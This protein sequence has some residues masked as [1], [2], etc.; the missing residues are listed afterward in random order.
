MCRSSES[1]MSSSITATLPAS[2]DCRIAC[3]FPGAPI[4]THPSGY[5]A[6]GLLSLS[7]PRVMVETENTVPIGR[8]PTLLLFWLLCA[9]TVTPKGYVTAHSS[10]ALMILWQIVSMA[11]GVAISLSRTPDAAASSPVMMC[12]SLVAAAAT[13]SCSVPSIS[14][15]RPSISSSPSSFHRSTTG[16]GLSPMY[17]LSKCSIIAWYFFVSFSAAMRA[18]NSSGLRTVSMERTALM[19]GEAFLLALLSNKGAAPLF[20]DDPTSSTTE[21]FP[22]A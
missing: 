3:S 20:D 19:G 1:V 4:R 8:F 10:S 13:F 15:S 17:F 22:S 11:N 14:S 5:P 9:R 16:C 7:H 18:C 12:L 6:G 21:A 2:S